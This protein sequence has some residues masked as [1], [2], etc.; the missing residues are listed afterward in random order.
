MMVNHPQGT[1]VLDTQPTWAWLES[2]D[3][4]NL[5]N[6]TRDYRF[7]YPCSVP[8][9]DA[10]KDPGEALNVDGISKYEIVEEIHPEVVMRLTGSKSVLCV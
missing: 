9:I 6:I 7:A 3:V 4:N 10:C 5:V 8:R 2:Y 1:L